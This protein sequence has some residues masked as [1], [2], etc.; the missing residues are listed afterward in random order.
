[1][2]TPDEKEEEWRGGRGRAE[3]PLARRSNTSLAHAGQNHM[4][5]LPSGREDDTGDLSSGL[6]DSMSDHVTGLEGKIGD[7]ATGLDDEMG[8]VASGLDVELWRAASAGQAQLAGALLALGA[9]PN[10]T[11]G[12][13]QGTTV[14]GTPPHLTSCISI[15]HNISHTSHQITSRRT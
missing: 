1:M 13:S 12:L 4:A 14:G 8:D 3:E 15:E 7:L 10:A 6:V 2:C 9:D 11:L 5:H